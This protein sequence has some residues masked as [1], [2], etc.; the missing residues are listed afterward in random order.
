MFKTRG[1]IGVASGEP[2]QGRSYRTDLAWYRFFFL[3][4]ANTDLATAN[5]NLDDELSERPETLCERW[6]GR[7]VN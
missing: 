5:P 1:N 4:D 2:R 6:F 7:L 3:S